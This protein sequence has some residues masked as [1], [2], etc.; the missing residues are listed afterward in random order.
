MT[1]REEFLR[2]GKF[3]EKGK[4]WIWDMGTWA[5]TL[6][7]W[8]KEGMPGDDHL[9]NIFGFD[10]TQSIPVNLGLLPG[11]EGQIIE[12]TRDYRIR[13]RSDGVKSKEFIPKTDAET[14]TPLSMSQWLEFPVK[15]KKS[16]ERLKQRL[17]PHSPARYPVNWEDL[18]RMWKEREYPLILPGP[19]FYGWVRGWVGMENLALMFYDNPS[20]VHEM[21]DYIAD[22]SIEV[23]RKA[24]E[25][26]EIDCVCFWEDMAYK[27]ASLISPKMFRDF[28][29]P[30]CKKVTDLLRSHG[31]EIIMVDSDGNVEELIPLWL[32]GGS[33]R[34]ISF[35]GSQWYGCC[36]SAQEIW[37]ES[38]LSREY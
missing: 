23:L 29:L 34:S 31:I 26:V 15:D 5:E 35:R 38:H 14:T 30:N 25:E 12:E 1:G 10:Y 19:S 9:L 4:A 13:I 37:E 28:I 32:E 33:Q 11:F 3:E 20:L 17:D 21:M 7:R 22:F 2:I 6:V 27:T 8:R 36:A 16:W 18:K 24:V